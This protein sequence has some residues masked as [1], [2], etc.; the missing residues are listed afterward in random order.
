MHHCGCTTGV[1]KGATPTQAS[2]VKAESQLVHKPVV[3]QL[4]FVTGSRRLGQLWLLALRGSCSPAASPA[5]LQVH[6]RRV[7]GTLE[8]N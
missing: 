3:R 6:G 2:S 5:P 7:I 4:G 1:Q 8:R